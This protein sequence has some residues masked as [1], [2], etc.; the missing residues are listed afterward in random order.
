MKSRERDRSRSSAHALLV[1]TLLV[2]PILFL[3]MFGSQV[4]NATS[5]DQREC[6]VAASRLARAHQRFAAIVCTSSGR[7]VVFLQNNPSPLELDALN[8]APAPALVVMTNLI[9]Q[10]AVSVGDHEVAL[11]HPQFEDAGERSALFTVGAPAVSIFHVAIGTSQIVGLTNKAVEGPA[12]LLALVVPAGEGEESPAG[13]NMYSYEP[14]DN[15]AQSLFTRL[16]GLE[17]LFAYVSQQ[18]AQQLIS[19]YVLQPGAWLAEMPSK[20]SRTQP[21]ALAELASMREHV[22]QRLLSSGRNVAMRHWV[23]FSM[24]NASEKGAGAVDELD[25]AVRVR[26]SI[27]TKVSAG[28]KVTFAR[29]PHF[30]CTATI[31]SSGI[32]RCR[33]Y[34]SHGDSDDETGDPVTVATFSGDVGEDTIQL[35]TTLVLRR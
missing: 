14:N 35:P 30:I 21:Q 27:A 28:A 22:A 15:G 13:L 20:R 23:S 10:E 29:S 11:I 24:T 34:D 4:A 25:V 2:A 5:A 1:H 17:H 33:L 7:L 26:S 12:T 6:E 16:A 31:D 32:A 18:P 8:R 3:A 9:A 19:I